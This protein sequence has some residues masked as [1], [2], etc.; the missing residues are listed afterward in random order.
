[1]LVLEF[2]LSKYAV[3]F[4]IYHLKLKVQQIKG[5][6]VIMHTVC[7]WIFYVNACSA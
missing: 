6:N 5:I 2:K 4:S 3:P 7:G 1:M